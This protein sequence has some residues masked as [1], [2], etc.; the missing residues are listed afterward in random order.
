MV[1]LVAG[2][3]VLAIGLYFLL[4][5]GHRPQRLQMAYVTVWT[6]ATLAIVLVHL[7]RI[8]RLRDA[9]IGRRGAGRASGSQ[10]SAGAR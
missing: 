8:R 9:A 3:D 6:L 5:V 1:L 10:S 2:L 7:H 4:D